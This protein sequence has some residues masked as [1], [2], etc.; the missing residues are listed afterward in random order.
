LGNLPYARGPLASHAGSD[1][2]AHL[3][4][5]LLVLSVEK[6]AKYF[7]TKAPRHQEN[8]NERFGF[9]LF[10]VHRPIE[11]LGALVSWW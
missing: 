9:K 5:R 11:V 7:T 4:R 1:F 6:I 8:Q 10:S 3:D 2:P